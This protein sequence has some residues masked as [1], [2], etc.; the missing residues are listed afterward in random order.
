MMRTELST[1]N[2]RDS[3]AYFDTLRNAMRV[4]ALGATVLHGI[5]GNIDIPGLK[6]SATSASATKNNL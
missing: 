1:N 3:E 5:V 4:Q 6:A 2:K